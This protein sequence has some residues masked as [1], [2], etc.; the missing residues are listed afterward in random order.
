MHTWALLV[1]LAILVL[2]AGVASVLATIRIRRA[3]TLHVGARFFP[4][5]FLVVFP[6]VTLGAVSGF[7]GIGWH[8]LPWYGAYIVLR[9]I[10]G[11]VIGGVAGG[12]LGAAICIIWWTSRRRVLGLA[13]VGAAVL[14]LNVTYLLV[15]EPCSGLLACRDTPNVVRAEERELLHLAREIFRKYKTLPAAHNA[16]ERPPEPLAVRFSQADATLT[17]AGP[18]YSGDLEYAEAWYRVYH[19]YHRGTGTVHLR[20]VWKSGAL[21][22]DFP[23][24]EI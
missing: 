19:K 7:A 24:S 11:F 4:R 16:F 3:T 12:V 9:P 6:L 5:I 21:S 18:I 13:V 23:V 17:T 8:G 15:Y 2:I 14:F 22:Q 20:V 10:A 1:A